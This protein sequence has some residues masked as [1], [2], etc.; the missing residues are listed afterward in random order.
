MTGFV[1]S[2][3]AKNLWKAII[4]KRENRLIAYVVS[5][6]SQWGRVEEYQYRERQ[7]L[8]YTRYI[9]DD[10]ICMI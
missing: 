2:G 9:I 1:K 4:A 3:R 8:G 6:P 10:V 5:Y 7:R